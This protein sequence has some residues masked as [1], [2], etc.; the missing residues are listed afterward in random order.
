[1]T[2]SPIKRQVTDNSFIFTELLPSLVICEAS[3]DIHNWVNDEGEHPAF[4]VYIGYNIP[5]E[6]E[7]WIVQLQMFWKIPIENISYRHSTRV[8]SYWWEMKIR[9]MQRFS[10]PEVFD[11][12][13]LTES[14]QY[15]LDFLQYLIQ[16][17]ME[18][19]AYDNAIVTNII[20]RG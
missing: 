20:T 15:G 2:V 11:L 18:E 19:D 4:L 17:R 3:R 9:G 7:D 6:R 8:K 14:K 12:D 13:Y 10:E 1:M 5:Q 16:I